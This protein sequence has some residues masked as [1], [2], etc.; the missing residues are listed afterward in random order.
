MIGA[1]LS[2]VPGSSSAFVGG[3]ITYSNDLKASE[4]GVPADV[5]ERHGAVSE[6]VARAMAEGGL[7]AADAEHAL[8]VTGVA[9]PGGGSEAKPVGTVFIAR[10]WRDGA[11]PHSEVRRFLL[12]GDR[13]TVRTRSVQLALTM[14][15]LGMLGVRNIELLG[16]RPMR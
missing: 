7:I 5:L 3:W 16:Q 12:P 6:P 8:A 14:L 1:A 9:G 2:D 13:Q 15:R 11:R 10:A 4:V